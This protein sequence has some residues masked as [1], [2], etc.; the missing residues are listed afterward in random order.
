MNS[1]LKTVS[2]ENNI[3]GI[4]HFLEE[5][6][7]KN[8]INEW[9]ADSKAMKN[10]KQDVIKFQ[11]QFSFPKYN[12]VDFLEPW[13]I[14]VFF[15]FILN[16]FSLKKWNKKFM[17]YNEWDTRKLFIFPPVFILYEAEKKSWEKILK[18]KFLLIPAN[19]HSSFFYFSFRLICW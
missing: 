14:N 7:L 17:Q 9:S 6:P 15:Y 10:S 2:L 11:L 18:R 8:L 5:F 3:M 16:K 19:Y 1:L 12:T 13:M 4:F